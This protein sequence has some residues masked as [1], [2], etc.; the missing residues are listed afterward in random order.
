MGSRAGPIV[1]RE[2]ARTCR[3]GAQGCHKRGGRGRGE[4]L[5]LC[6]LLICTLGR[7][8]LPS[9]ACWVLRSRTQPL[10]LYRNIWPPGCRCPPSSNQLRPGRSRTV[11][12]KGRW[13][14]RDGRGWNPS[15][16]LTSDSVPEGGRG[17]GGPWLRWS[18]P[19]LTRLE[20]WDH[21]KQAV[22][23]KE[24]PSGQNEA[25]SSCFSAWGMVL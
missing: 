9:P 4:R 21:L 2:D 15:P 20:G 5:R 16:H 14:G 3:I 24:A 22:T 17:V 7:K 25:S 8:P 1:G 11:V 10:S 13:S 12:H 23:L 19:C 18:L 6:S